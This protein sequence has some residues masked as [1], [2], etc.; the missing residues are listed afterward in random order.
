M[1]FNLNTHKE[2]VQ[3]S[4]WQDPQLGIMKWGISN[5]YPQTLINLI[6]QS[7]NASPAVTRVSEFYKGQG[8]EGEDLIVAPNGL[9]LKDVVGIMADDYAIFQ[10]FALHE[11]YNL[12]AQVSSITPMRIATLRFNEFDELNYASKVGYHP[13]FGLNSVERKNIQVPV[14]KGKIKWFNRFNPEAV[15]SQVEQDAKGKLGN[16]NGQILY[17]SK[18]G[19]S[20]YPIPPLQAPIN[21]VLSDIEN[22]I[23]VRKESSTGF[24]NSYLLKSTLASEDETLARLELEI[25]K[26]QGSRGSG[27]VITMSDLSPEEVSNNILEEIG[28]GGSGAKATIESSILTFDLDKKV[29]N[30]AYLIPPILAG[31]D[32]ANGFSGT[33]L[34]DAYNIFNALTQGGR[35]I[36]EQQINRVIE[37]SVFKGKIPP[38]KITP[39]TSKSTEEQEKEKESRLQAEQDRKIELQE[40]EVELQEKGKD[41]NIDS[42][43][44]VI[45]RNPLSGR[46]EQSLQ[47]IVRNYGKGKMTRSQAA[48]QLKNDLGFDDDRISTWLGHENE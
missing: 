18:A 15:E 6:A 34:E 3:V 13:N 5:S 38:V 9:T 29:I 7:A 40:K 25:A 39:L 21:Y 10:A 45:K 20:A 28:S 37:A 2:V 19:H 35:D 47:R 24:V 36:I 12:K 1:A 26:S 48:D 42:P 43:N 27:R 31:I 22:S 14:S 46:Q 32:V 17:Y 11:N 30:G 33:E 8:F 41:I 16:Y 44:N 4:T 23:L